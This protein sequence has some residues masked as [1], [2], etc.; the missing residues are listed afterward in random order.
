MNDAHKAH[1]DAAKAVAL[2]EGD[3]DCQKLEVQYQEK[4]Y[5]SAM[6]TLKECQQ[7]EARACEASREAAKLVK[8]AQDALIEGEARVTQ[9]Q[10]E[11][12]CSAV[13]NTSAVEDEALQKHAKELGERDLQ[14][15]HKTHAELEVK[16]S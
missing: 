1:I 12:N 11:F 6:A 7:E 3:V 9:C 15:L 5:N 13:E 10:H 4:T 14:Q 8:D 2:A 16:R